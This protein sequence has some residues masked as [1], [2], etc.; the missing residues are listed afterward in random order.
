[1]MFP[2]L[3][4]AQEVNIKDNITGFDSAAT[5][6]LNNQTAGAGGR[7][8]LLT[9][10]TFAQR[11]QVTRFFQVSS[12][13]TVPVA[14]GFSYAVRS[15]AAPNTLLFSGT[16][17]RINRTV[18]PN[19]TL[20]GNN[21]NLD[22]FQITGLT[23]D[24]GTYYFTV[25]ASDGNAYQVA[26]HSSLATEPLLAE[27]GGVPFLAGANFHLYTSLFA[28]LLN[29]EVFSRA[30]RNFI[31]RRADQITANSPDLVRRLTD[32]P[33]DGAN[34]P[35][36]FT[37][38]GTTQAS[39]LSFSTSL[40]DFVSANGAQLAQ[41]GNL[42]AFGPQGVTAN[43][44]A[45]PGETGLG[46]WVQGWFSHLDSGTAETDLGQFYAG[47]D[48]RLSA[49]LVVGALA[50]FDWSDEDDNPNNTSL[51]GDGWLVGPYVV[52]RVHDN[53]IFDALATFGQ[54]DN[55][56]ST[57]TVTGEFDTDRFY[58]KGQLTGDFAYGDWHFAPHVAVHYFEE[59]Q[60]SYT[61]SLGGTIASQTV[62]L[63]RA[64]FGPEVST[65]F[66]MEDGTVIAPRAAIKGLWDFDRTT[67][68][69]PTTG[70][71]V[72]TDDIRARLEGG[73][74]VQLANG[75]HLNGGA[76][77]DGIGADDFDA[78]GGNVSV[79]VPLN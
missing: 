35:V 39:Q 73:L 75:W 2:A 74:T 78:Y 8:I 41:P 56:V 59:H 12:S 27:N 18:Y 43:F 22:E 47:I 25:H 79:S 6:S 71:A 7:Q 1:M 68:V 17:T 13:T 63:G 62:S 5:N 50:Q 33:G 31:S 57:A 40:Y 24:P 23:L 9:Q 70:L 60:E 26:A 21:T 55:D 66:V 45:G 28:I 77:Y 11:A 16:A 54:S 3:A 76:F 51:D 46:F 15:L 14:N 36:G 4:Q 37:V 20:A 32:R 49:D 34:G 30:A 64:T 52:A 72:G 61:N 19:V 67:T 44:G 48:Y 69:N 65:R 58:V 53:V 10:H 38:D 29:E 42:Q